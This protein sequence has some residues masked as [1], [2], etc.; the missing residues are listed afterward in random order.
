VEVH[1]QFRRAFAEKLLVA[2]VPRVSHAESV[3]EVSAQKLAPGRKKLCTDV[4]LSSEFHASAE[5]FWFDASIDFEFRMPV[6]DQ[7]EV[8]IAFLDAS[9]EALHS[10]S[11]Q[12]DTG[13]PHVVA[14]VGDYVPRLDD[15]AHVELHARGRVERSGHLATL[16]LRHRR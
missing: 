6:A 1:G 16:R 7:L 4:T 15:G 11:R 5:K 13:G 14:S 10:F 9:G 3:W 12:V 2:P 8:Y